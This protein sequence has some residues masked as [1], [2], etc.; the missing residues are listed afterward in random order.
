MDI[1]TICYKFK[2]TTIIILVVEICL[3]INYYLPQ[4]LPVSKL[5]QEMIFH[6]PT[7]A[8]PYAGYFVATAPWMHYSEKVKDKI[9]YFLLKY[10]GK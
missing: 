7:S 2:K 5:V 6:Q 4:T 8:L 10:A 3:F 1:I 9:I